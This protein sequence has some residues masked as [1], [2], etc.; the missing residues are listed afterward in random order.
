MKVLIITAFLGIFG[1]NLNAQ[2][3]YFSERND[4]FTHERTLNLGNAFI[5]EFLQVNGSVFVKDT[6]K[7]FTVSFILPDLNIKTDSVGQIKK[8]CQ[9]MT[10]MDK[11]IIG[12]WENSTSATVAGNSYV[13]YI[14]S[15][16]EVD[17]ITLSQANI[18]AV[19]FNGSVYTIEPKNQ[20]KV[21]K[22]C[23]EL[24]SKF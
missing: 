8:E 21:R 12:K 3:L 11:I 17:F 6:T 14:Y 20:N 23:A 18:T 22:L 4:P 19:K 7:K 16:S 2:K 10:V 9:I 1:Y 15:I 13:G 24:L 5:T